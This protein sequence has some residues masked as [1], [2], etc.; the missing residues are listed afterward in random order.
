MGMLIAILI[1]GQTWTGW[2]FWIILTRKDINT[3]NINFSKLES[4]KGTDSGLGDLFASQDWK[5]MN[6]NNNQKTPWTTIIFSHSKLRRG[7]I[8][9][10][11][12][13]ISGL[14]HRHCM[15]LHIIACLVFACCFWEKGPSF[16]LFYKHTYQKDRSNPLK[17]L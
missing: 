5:R 11:I 7:K 13:I 3:G 10:Q 15:Y 14:Q 6:N 9:Y 17:V 8:N 1:T 4:L 12:R 16:L 2:L